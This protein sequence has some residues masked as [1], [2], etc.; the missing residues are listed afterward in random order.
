VTP[1]VDGGQI[2]Y[3]EAVDISD[4]KSGDEVAAKILA[5]EHLAYKK[6]ID[7]FSK[8]K[9]KIEGKRAVFVPNK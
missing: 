9:Y 6:V 5:R 1:E 4:C 7:S 8:G 2:I 3:Q